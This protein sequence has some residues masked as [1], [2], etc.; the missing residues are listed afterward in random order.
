MKGELFNIFLLIL[1][2]NTH[3]DTEEMPLQG[4]TPI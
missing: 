1:K 3:S 4:N 2:G